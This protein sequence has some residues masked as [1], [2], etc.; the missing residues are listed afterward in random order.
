MQSAPG[1]L[2]TLSESK[3]G[4]MIHDSEKRLSKMVKEALSKFKLKLKVAELE[5]RE[6]V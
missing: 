1:R 2:G 6:D 4:T 5:K 3:L